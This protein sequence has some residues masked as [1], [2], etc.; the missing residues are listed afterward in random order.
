[1]EPGPQRCES[2][3]MCPQEVYEC[4]RRGLLNDPSHGVRALSANRPRY[5][6][7]LVMAWQQDKPTR[8]ST[9]KCSITSAH[10]S[11][12]V[13]RTVYCSEVSLTTTDR[14]WE[15]YGGCGEPKRARTE[16]VP[17]PR[18]RRSRAESS[19][20]PCI[21]AMRKPTVHHPPSAGAL[22]RTFIRSLRPRLGRRQSSG[23][24]GM[25]IQRPS[26]RVGT[27]SAENR[28]PDDK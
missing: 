28:K 17:P 7:P 19:P 18:S 14:V 13:R 25:S 8:G 4:V 24:M 21:L 10:C 1:M 6:M 3:A 20:C 12:A 23:S 5:R 9:T 22:P 2:H 27:P 11:P 16:N 26:S 15:L